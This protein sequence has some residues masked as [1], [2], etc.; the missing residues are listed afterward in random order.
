MCRLLRKAG[1]PD[2]SPGHPDLLA[3]IA[4]GA[5]DAEFTSAG[6]TAADKGKGFAY[7]LGVLKG[8]RTEAAEASKRM[9]HGALSVAANGDRKTR[10]LETAAL[11]T[12]AARAEPQPETI[13]V[14]SRVIAPRL[15]G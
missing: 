3:L 12:G 7:A 8:Q 15:L 11:M 4:A 1:V 13:D 9:H 2:A 14:D 10:Q 6:R 5:S